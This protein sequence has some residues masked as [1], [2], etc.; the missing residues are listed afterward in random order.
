MS[1][2]WLLQGTELLGSLELHQM[3]VGKLKGTSKTPLFRQK[4]TLRDHW[5]LTLPEQTSN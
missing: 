3:N 4:P 2:L 1:L 5:G